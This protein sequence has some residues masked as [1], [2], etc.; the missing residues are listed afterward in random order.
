MNDIRTV[1][2]FQTDR[3]KKVKKLGPNT[4]KLSVS[5]LTLMS[6]VGFQTSAILGQLFRHRNIWKIMPEF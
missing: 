1:H 3:I 5:N 2:V 6:E 4:V